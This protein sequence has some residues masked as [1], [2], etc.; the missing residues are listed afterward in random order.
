MPLEIVNSL[1]LVNTLG[2]GF[3]AAMFIFKTWK[4]QNTTIDS[5]TIAS[6]SRQIEVFKGELVTYKQ[7]M[8]DMTLKVGE[9]MGIIASQKETI[10]KYEKILQN[11]N[12][13]LTNILKEI[14]EFM[15]KIDEKSTVTMKELGFQTGLL[16]KQEERSSKLDKTHA[17]VIHTL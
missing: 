2:L 13:E 15:R 3:L 14:S 1:P 6:L 8:H 5:E 10:E 17:E 9:Q 4:N 12:P 7:Q 16:K 11:R